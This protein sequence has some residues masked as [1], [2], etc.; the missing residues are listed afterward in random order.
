M[1]TGKA[2]RCDLRDSRVDQVDMPYQRTWQRILQGAYGLPT[3]HGVLEKSKVGVEQ[4][5]RFGHRN[6]DTEPVTRGG[7]GCSGKVVLREP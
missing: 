4:L 7:D 1:L 3:C 6:V 5:I 2:D